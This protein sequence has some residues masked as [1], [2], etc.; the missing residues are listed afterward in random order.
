MK[1]RMLHRLS[2][3]LMALVLMSGCASAS[4]LKALEDDKRGCQLGD[5]HACYSI[6]FDQATVDESKAENTKTAVTVAA[7]AVLLPLIILGAAAAAQ[8]PN[9]VVVARCRGWYC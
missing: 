4:S 6:P 7:I 2:A 8:Q 1:T 9:Y 3:S 5:Q